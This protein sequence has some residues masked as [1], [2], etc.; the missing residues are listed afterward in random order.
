MCELFLGGGVG[1]EINVVLVTPRLA[2][3]RAMQKIFSKRDHVTR[4]GFKRYTGNF[5]GMQS[6]RSKI[7]II[8]ART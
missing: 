4:L 5:G 7:R 2:T 3:E 6:K 8:I 1:H